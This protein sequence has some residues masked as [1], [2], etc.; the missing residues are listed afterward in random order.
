MTCSKS[1][2]GE[3]RVLSQLAEM[4]AVL[5]LALPLVARSQTNIVPNGSFEETY[6]DGDPFDWR[7]TG[8][9]GGTDGTS[10]QANAADGQAFNAGN[11]EQHLVT[12]PGQD[13]LL[14]FAYGGSGEYLNE[15]KPWPLRVLWGSDILI[16]A[17]YRLFG[18]W[19][20]ASQP[21]WTYHTFLV[22]AHSRT[23][24]LRFFC[25]T[26]QLGRVSD[27]FA[28]LDDV[29]VVSLD[30][31]DALSHISLPAISGLGDIHMFQDQVRPVFLSVN[32][33]EDWASIFCLRVQSSNPDL[34]PNEGIGFRLYSSVGQP[35]LSFA[36]AKG[37]TGSATITVTLS[38]ALASTS[39]SFKLIVLSTPPAIEPEQQVVALGAK[40]A[41]SIVA[42]LHDLVRYQ[43]DFNGVPISG[44][45][46]ATLEIV[47]V[48]SELEGVYNAI[49]SDSG[50]AVKRCRAAVLSLR[51]PGGAIFFSNRTSEIDAP[52]MAED[53]VTK[54]SGEQY[55]A[56]LYA[57]V[58]A[59]TLFPV[60]PAA[61]FRDEPAAGYWSLG[62]D[63][64][65]TIPW[66]GAAQPVF[67][68]VRAWE[69]G[70]GSTYEETVAKGGAI[71]SSELLRF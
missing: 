3:K 6:Q 28:L 61:P 34:I 20:E 13:Y 32:G 37:M 29:S 39:A 38:D 69:A 71:G 59:D 16:A 7:G 36:P 25:D 56:Q 67:V 15:P 66:I 52:V 4:L 8:G 55:L 58:A 50:G 68:Q 60:G 9:T 17:P 63:G 24:R 45:T 41:F 27:E 30:P 51:R 2:L 18:S 43:W 64:I 46:N 47:S 26:G 22:R 5:L 33:V 14:R 42:P 54:L 35:M 40:A 44:A 1:F 21:E 10:W 11:A 70:L 62:P 48:R 53:G 49:V 31:S 65:R 19:W 23:T 12:V 57:G